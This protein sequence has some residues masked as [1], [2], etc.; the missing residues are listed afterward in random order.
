MGICQRGKSAVERARC[1]TQFGSVASETPP[2]RS[3]QGRKDAGIINLKIPG[4]DPRL[5]CGR[6]ARVTPDRDNAPSS[7][8]LS[9]CPENRLVGHVPQKDL[10][11][12]VMD[13]TSGQSRKGGLADRLLLRITY[14]IDSMTMS[15][16][17]PE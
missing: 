16:P 13:P 4:N 9:H 14:Y 12:N 11:N 7:I 3:I 17:A 15:A 10:A 1:V 5:F 6:S 8:G 2:T